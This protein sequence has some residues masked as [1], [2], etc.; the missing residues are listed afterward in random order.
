MHGLKFRRQQPIAD[1]IVDF[2]CFEKKVVVELDGG[3][4][5]GQKTAD[6]KR[7][8]FLKTNGF[9][10]LR[11]WNNDVFDN[12]S[13]VLEKISQACLHPSP[14]PPIEGGELM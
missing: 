12:L 14:A 6:E 11:F 10:V 4:H 5:A 8:Q 2:V 1:Y 7:D 9:T 13:G 3:Q